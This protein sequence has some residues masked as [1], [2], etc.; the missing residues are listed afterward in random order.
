MLEIQPH[1]EIDAARN[2][3]V[4]EVDSDSARA[5]HRCAV[6]VDDWIKA[7]V[8]GPQAKIGSL[9]EHARVPR[10]EESFGKHV[11][12]LNVPQPYPVDVLLD[13]QLLAHQTVVIRL[14]AGNYDDVFDRRIRGI[15]LSV[16]QHSLDHPWRIAIERLAAQASR[17]QVMF[18]GV[19]NVTATPNVDQEVEREIVF[20]EGV[21]KTDGVLRLTIVAVVDKRGRP[22]RQSRR[23]IDQQIAVVV[24][25]I[26]QAGQRHRGQAWHGAVANV[27]IEPRIGDVRL[28]QRVWQRDDNPALLCVVRYEIPS[29]AAGRLDRGSTQCDLGSFISGRRAIQ[30]EQHEAGA[31]A[32]TNVVDDLVEGLR[33]VK[34]RIEPKAV[35]EEAQLGAE[36]TRSLEIRLESQIRTPEVVAVSTV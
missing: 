34:R 24:S 16:A 7:L 27:S 6:A 17:R 13:E 21:G 25:Q 11:A 33:A 4:A 28:R 26:E 2:R 8:V 5:T 9:D 15:L 10:A 14:G 3:N 35:V 20:P 22:N 23:R 1:A 30:V 29:E 19:E 18:G 12:H 36:L 31:I 32:A